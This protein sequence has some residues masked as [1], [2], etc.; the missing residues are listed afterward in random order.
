[1]N[2]FTALTQILE[3]IIQCCRMDMGEQLDIL[4]IKLYK[5]MYQLFGDIP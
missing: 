5:K 2:K 4:I 3:H 1:M